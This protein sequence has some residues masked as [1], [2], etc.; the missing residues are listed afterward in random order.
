MVVEDERVVARDI[1]DSLRGMGYE[2]VGS[3][4]SAEE[5]LRSAT[6]RC[7]DLVLMDVRIQGQLDGI[8]TAKILRS[9]F[10][11]PVI[12]LTAYADTETVN[13]AR[14]A[15]AH[16]YLLK[17]FRPTELKSAVEIA[18]FKHRAE[19]R[20]REQEQWFRTT[21]RAIADAVIA[22]D[23]HGNVTF[24][25]QIA[26][27]LLGRSESELKGKP[28][29][30]VFQLIDEL[31][32]EPIECPVDAALSE[33]KI[34]RLPPNTALRGRDGE[35]PID[36]SVAPIMDERGAVLG[37]VIV[38][39][40]ASEQRSTLAQVALADRLTSLGVLAA[41]VAHEINNPLTYV[42]GNAT[43]AAKD[44]EQVRDALAPERAG[45]DVAMAGVPERIQSIARDLNEIQHGAERIS[46]IVA[47]LRVFARPDDSGVATDVIE[48]LEWALRVSESQL[49]RRARLIKAI[50]PV[51]RVRGSDGRLGQVFLN[52][53][54][55]AA[56][57]IDEGQPERNFITVTTGRDERGWVV[58]SVQ[59]TGAGMHPEIARRVFEPFFTTKP[60]GV[61]TG[62]GLSI[63]HG[64]VL[65]MGGELVVEST[66]NY[67]STFQ[68]YLPIVDEGS[69]R[70][71]RPRSVRP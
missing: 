12:Y 66:P 5:C 3:A 13:R 17:P 58:V 41:G 20:L 7:P 53:L 71:A 70:P 37:A 28:L 32:R 56:Q 11:V 26:E 35:R 10:G 25:N 23:N 48:A 50:N 45:D 27:S 8:E 36:D 59:D 14:E 24:A 15:E 39:R 21:L 57:A 29:A 49:I 68:V 51:P 44:L 62:L 43:L 16:G 34:G 61:G 4:A 67:G 22:V 42:L 31:T 64:I 52:L 55:N 33:G 40:D 2:V 1:E 65:A 46:R 9:R 60:V 30:D 63:C 19:N 6:N 69:I 54:I 47:D 18:L 38:F